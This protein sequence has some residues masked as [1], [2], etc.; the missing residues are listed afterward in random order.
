MTFFQLL[1]FSL[2][3]DVSYAS[4]SCM[5]DCTR[6]LTQRPPSLYEQYCCN[7]DNSGKTIKL[8]K[9]NKVK[10][11]FCPSNL[12]IPCQRFFTSL[13]NCSNIFRENASAVS[14]YYD[15]KGSYGLV[16]S[17]YCDIVDYINELNFSDCYET[18]ENRSCAPSG[19][20][21]I[22]A[23]N[24][25][26]LSV[27]CD[28]EGSNCDGKGGWMRVGYLNMTEPNAICP[29]YLTQRQ[30]NNIDHDV[31]GR[32]NSGM[33]AHTFFSTKGINY[34]KVCGQLRGY[35]Y[36]SPDG[37]GHGNNN[38]DSCYVDGISITY[39]SS[40]RKHIWTHVNGFTSDNVPHPESSCPCNTNNTIAPGHK[41]NLV[42]DDYYCESGIPSY[43]IDRWQQVLYASD[44][45]WDGQQ[46]DGN[47]GPCCT[48]PKMPWFIKTLNE[49]TTEDIEIRVCGNQG[50]SDEDTLLDI[51]ELYIK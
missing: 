40:P 18:F 35:Q 10:I 37:F 27:Y 48:N 20:Y 19:F 4:S 41:P 33:S 39:G 32:P 51:I 25:S 30:Y 3:L 21:K 34:N 42:G 2:L 23:S 49:N 8:S 47:E 31:C 13:D 7:T 36:Q 17:V 43:L 5:A 9:N 16:F 11:I 14:G 1:L 45:L 29:H 12:P 22:Q 38:I 15:F 46:C 44:A 26:L 24:G 6:L 50:Y 28:M